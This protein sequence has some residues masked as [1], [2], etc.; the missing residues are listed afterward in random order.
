[1]K[2]LKLFENFESDLIEVLDHNSLRIISDKS[3]DTITQF[4]FDLVSEIADQFKSVFGSDFSDTKCLDPTIKDDKK[5][6]VDFKPNKMV[7]VYFKFKSMDTLSFNKYQ[8]DWW[9]CIIDS[10]KVERRTIFG[11]TLFLWCDGRESLSDIYEFTIKRGFLRQM[12]KESVSD[13]ATGLMTQINF[14][15]FS[16][17]EDE[18]ESEREQLT[19]ADVEYFKSKMKQTGIPYDSW[20]RFDNGLIFRLK[21]KSDYYNSKHYNTI[22]FD[23][24][25]DDWWL[26]EIISDDHIRDSYDALSNFIID[27]REGLEEFFK[28]TKEPEQCV[29]FRVGYGLYESKQNEPIVKVLDAWSQ[30]DDFIDEHQYEQFRKEELPKIKWVVDQ[31][32]ERL[33]NHLLNPIELSSSRL[34]YSPTIQE[35]EITDDTKAKKLSGRSWDWLINVHK[36]E[37]EWWMV[38]CYLP[39]VSSPD[40]GDHVYFICDTTDGLVALPD[41]F[42]KYIR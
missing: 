5:R 26:C 12:V 41:F 40:G 33:N 29:Y 30:A 18:Y 13:L 1:M 15:Q 16:D 22:K 23:K 8:D 31:L 27:S 34:N 38:E 21:V 37:D 25:K 35:N 28:W 17:L 7:S 36:F 4:E 10:E 20:G 11:S 39:E 24:Y 2:H 42:S 3:F 6:W 14:E 9:L 19:D 32:I